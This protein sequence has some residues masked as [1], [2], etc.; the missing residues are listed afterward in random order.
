M[1]KISAW[2][3]PFVIDMSLNELNTNFSNLKKNDII[4]IYIIELFM[5]LSS[6][7]NNDFNWNKNK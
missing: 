6:S 3:N 4:S 5:L 1:N 7:K 2:N